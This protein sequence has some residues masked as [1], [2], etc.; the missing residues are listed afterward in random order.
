[1]WGRELRAGLVFVMISLVLGAS[2]RG[3]RR[4]HETRFQD[5][6]ARLSAEAPPPPPPDGSS[7]GPTESPSGAISDR[8]ARARSAMR[9]HDAGPR[10]GSIDINRAG[11]EELMG[12]PG[13]GPALAD[14]ILADRAARGA[15]PQPGALL[16]VPGIGPRILERLRPYLSREAERDSYPVDAK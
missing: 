14:R 4:A 7:P 11:R 9:A 3:W 16:R 13:I 12:L 6:V 1:M 2:V 10:P 8:G 15:F 5:L